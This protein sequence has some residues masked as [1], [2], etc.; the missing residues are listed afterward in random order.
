MMKHMYVLSDHKIISHRFK[1]DKVKCIDL[2]DVLQEGRRYVITTPRKELMQKL[3]DVRDDYHI[4][5][6]GMDHLKEY[7]V[8]NK[9]SLM[10]VHNCYVQDGDVEVCDISLD[11]LGC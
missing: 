5:T 2:R 10:M 4:A 9:V 1:G 3:K 7:C 8:A 6:I 11:D